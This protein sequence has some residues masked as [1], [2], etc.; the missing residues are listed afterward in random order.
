[1]LVLSWMAEG[2][3]LVHTL[4]LPRIAVLVIDVPRQ[5]PV[6][7]P[8]RI[9]GHNLAGFVRGFKTPFL[10]DRQQEMP[11]RICI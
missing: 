3:I 9:R 7:I 1:M 8:G 4:F 10:T 6:V 5:N 11:K 2:L